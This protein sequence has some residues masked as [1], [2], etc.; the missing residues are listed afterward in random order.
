MKRRG[1]T[2]VELSIVLVIIGLLVGGVLVGQSL[3][4]SAK[5]VKTVRQL[6]QTEIAV[7]NFV[8]KFR[9][10]PGDST[11]GFTNNGNGNLIIEP[12]L[13]EHVY[14]W[15]HLAA[16]ESFKPKLTSTN[17]PILPITGNPFVYITANPTTFAAAYYYALGTLEPTDALSLDKKMDDALPTSGNFVNANSALDVYDYTGQEDYVFGCF[18]STPSNVENSYANLIE[19]DIPAF[20]FFSSQYNNKSPYSFISYSDC[21]DD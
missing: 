1:F 18:L 2:L 16:T 14:V 6:E 10:I 15:E 9:S 12:N 4:E 20:P 5:L 13:N 8:Q 7:Q 21:Y 11:L 17:T 3:I 19:E